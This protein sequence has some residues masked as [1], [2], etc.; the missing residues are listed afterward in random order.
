MLN[1]IILL[2]LNNLNKVGNGCCISSPSIENPNYYYHWTKDAALSMLAIDKLYI[3]NKIDDIAYFTRF[4][5]YVKFES[6][7]LD[8][9]L[10]R[11]EV[12]YNVNGTKTNNKYPLN[13]G[14]ALRVL[15][16]DNFFLYN[17]K[18]ENT[19]MIDLLYDK[20]NKN[21]SII[22]S[23]LEYIC[24]NAFNKSYDFW[25]DINDHHLTTKLFERNALEVGINIATLM[26]DDNA[27][28]KYQEYYNYVNE[29]ILYF[30]NFYVI[31][32]LNPLVN[33][34]KDN[35]DSSILIALDVCNINIDM[36]LVSYVSEIVKYYRDNIKINKDSKL[37]LIG[38]Y[39]NDKYFGNNVWL[40]C[41]IYLV[42]FYKRL[43][44]EI[45]INMILS[46]YED[47]D[48]M[49][50]LVND[51]IKFLY[52]IGVNSN[53]S[54]QLDSNKLI[55]VSAEHLTLNYV[56]FINLLLNKNNNNK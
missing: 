16:L 45:H 32:H 25:E 48:D 34:Y 49:K 46:L 43:K 20:M 29:Y 11:G 9:G 41:T 28:N 35:L 7:I 36:C 50:S 12:K 53:W 40:L 55:S 21:K 33:N 24:K 44:D 17:F 54:E 56:A 23:D 2:F 39:P 37:Y 31:P 42:I 3:N 30:N 19:D 1:D 8:L 10:C 4:M 13:D 51:Y 27:V 22:K 6:G 52:D 5:E 26:K 15:A 38:R 18:K 14:P 47:Y